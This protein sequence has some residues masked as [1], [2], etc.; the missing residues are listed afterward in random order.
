MKHATIASLDRVEKGMYSRL[1]QIEAESKQT[2]R[3]NFKNMD[4]LQGVDL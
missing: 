3:K 1:K 2:A 4:E